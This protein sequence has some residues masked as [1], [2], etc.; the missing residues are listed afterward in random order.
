MEHGVTHDTLPTLE[1]IRTEVALVPP[2]L[3]TQEEHALI[4]KLVLQ[5]NTSTS[6]IPAILAE[7]IA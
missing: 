2:D 5:V 6:T 4:S 1:I 7:K 3:L